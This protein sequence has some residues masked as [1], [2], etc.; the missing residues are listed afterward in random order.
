M[1]RFDIY[2]YQPSSAG[3]CQCTGELLLCI[4]LGLI[5]TC[6]N[7]NGNGWDIAGWEALRG[8]R[9]QQKRGRVD[10][11]HCG[12]SCLIRSALVYPHSGDR[13]SFRWRRFP[14]QL[15]IVDHPRWL[16]QEIS[17]GSCR[18]KSWTRSF[19]FFP[20]ETLRCFFQYVGSYPNV[21]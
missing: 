7:R 4:F 2:W 1:G 11:V 20:Q 14:L 16:Q 19:I 8:G 5:N 17:T 18:Q 6:G 3:R 15:V 9:S 10:R 13:D 21:F 12:P